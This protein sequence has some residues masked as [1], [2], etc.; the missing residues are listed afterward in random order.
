MFWKLTTVC[1]IFSADNL[2]VLSHGSIFVG[3]C[4][5][6]LS[7][8]CPTRVV[9]NSRTITIQITTDQ[10]RNSNITY[11]HSIILFSSN[12]ITYL[13]VY[14]LVSLK[15]ELCWFVTFCPDVNISSLSS[16][17]YHVTCLISTSQTSLP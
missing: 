3:D 11:K 9:M 7:I 6:K 16:L 13:Y 15:F 2:L 5:P 12:S 14:I 17:L 4:V 8:R 10:Q 1:S